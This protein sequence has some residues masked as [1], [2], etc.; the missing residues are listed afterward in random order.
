VDSFAFP[1]CLQ[2]RLPQQCAV[3]VVQVPATSNCLFQFRNFNAEHTH[4]LRHRADFVFMHTMS[5]LSYAE[6]SFAD[7]NTLPERLDLL[8]LGGAN[9]YVRNFL[10]CRK[11]NKMRMWHCCFTLE[12]SFAA[13]TCNNEREGGGWALV[14]Q[15]RRGNTWHQAQDNLAGVSLYGASEL[16]PTADSTFSLQYHLLVWS[17]LQFLFTVGQ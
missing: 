5:F 3:R 16:R 10:L 12:Y 11:R 17:S 8:S 14:R 15:V 2:E 9:V 1:I 4:E 6:E 13:F 7:A